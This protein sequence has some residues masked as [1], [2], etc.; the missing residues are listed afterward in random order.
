[1]HHALAAAD[2]LTAERLAH[3]LKG[4]AAQVG[5]DELRNLATQLEE[6]VRRQEALPVLTA[7]LTEIAARLLEL[8]DA[9]RRRLPDKKSAPETEIIDP[10]TLHRLCTEL[11]H[12]LDTGDFCCSQSVQKNEPALRALLGT[13]FEDFS[14]RVDNYD[15]GSARLLLKAAAANQGM[16]I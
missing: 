15:F 8:S 11:A 13:Q 14:T 1:M 6:A 7:A 5:A 12:Q 3:T 10:E 16:V 2:W 9:I 4:V